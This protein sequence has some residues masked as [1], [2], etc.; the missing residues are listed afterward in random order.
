M[1]KIFHHI[2]IQSNVYEKSL[3]FY[4]KIMEFN[5]V[6]ES[7]NFH[8]R[9]YNTWLELNNFFIELQTNKKDEALIKFNKNNSGLVHFCIY[10]EDINIE[11]ERI[12]KLGFKNFKEKDGKDIYKVEDGF[13]CKLIAPEGTI[14]EIRDSW[15]II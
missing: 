14:I 12:K 1:K 5:I 13:L 7:E 15:N 4:T 10:V 2:C 3:E 9:A 11:Y 6:K 8:N